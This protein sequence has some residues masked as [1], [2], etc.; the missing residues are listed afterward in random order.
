[1]SDGR[2][3]DVQKCDARFLL[4]NNASNFGDKRL[5][6]RSTDKMNAQKFRVEKCFR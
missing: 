2:K 6:K 4:K 5:L 1:M 3:I